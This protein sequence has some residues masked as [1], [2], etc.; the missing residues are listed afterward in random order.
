MSQNKKNFFD[1]MLQEEETRLASFQ[2]EFLEES[3]SIPGGQDLPLAHKESSKS[4][5]DPAM[6]ENSISAIHSEPLQ[7][8]P[9]DQGIRDEPIELETDSDPVASIS[10]PTPLPDGEELSRAGVM[11]TVGSFYSDQLLHKAEQKISKLEL[12]LQK[13]S[14]SLQE[15]NS[16][17]QA[18]EKENLELVSSNK[19]ISSEL[20]LKDEAVEAEKKVLLESLS[21]KDIKIAALTSRVESLDEKI[22]SEYSNLK[23]RERELENRLLLL[24]KEHQVLAET[25]DENL[26]HLSKDLELSKNTHRKLKEQVERLNLKLSEKDELIIKI[27]QALDLAK[28]LT[29][30]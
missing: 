3:L 5:L 22:Q 11:P 17:I 14:K 28:T 7:L 19:K 27:T 23:I 21:S 10:A 30:S 15:K 8:V 18:L 2:D 4:S 1:D 29:Q 20:M 6:N 25:K 12:D 9:E 13:L 24:K 26:S 16:I